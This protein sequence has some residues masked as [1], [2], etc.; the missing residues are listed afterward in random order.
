MPMPD[1]RVAEERLGLRALGGELALELFLA[2]DVDE[3][4]VDVELAVVVA[5]DD[6]DVAHPHL[7]SV[8][9]P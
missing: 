7:A 4:A 5:I 6:A 9:V 3:I 2:G 1:R 8:C